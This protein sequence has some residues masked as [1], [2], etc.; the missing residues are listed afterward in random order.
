MIAYSLFG[1]IAD[2]R[3][4][5]KDEADEPLTEIFERQA[6]E[7]RDCESDRLQRH[8]AGSAVLW[9]PPSPSRR[10]RDQA[11][12]TDFK[13]T[14]SSDNSSQLTIEE[15]YQDPTLTWL[16]DQAVASNRELK[17][18]NEDVQ[19]ASNEVLARSGAYLPFVSL[20]A[21]AGLDRASRFTIPGAGIHQRPVSPRE[22][23]SQSASGISG[24]AS[25]SPGSWTSTGSCGMPGTRQG[26]ATTS[27]SRGGTTS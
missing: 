11:C 22:V 25:T 17:V 16:I 3:K 14:T 7:A 18:L 10:S 20:G 2:K 26:S 21:G 24:G 5:L 8:A 23:L 9:D 1:G 15:F 6:Y 27:P 19:I 13:G 12:R 4:L